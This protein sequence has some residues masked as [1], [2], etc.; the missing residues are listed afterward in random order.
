M[1]EPTLTSPGVW[2]T[3]EELKGAPEEWEDLP[4]PIGRHNYDSAE[5]FSDSIKETFMEEKDG[6]AGSGQKVWLPS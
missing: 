5:P 6:P 4:S 1:E 3:K 2:P